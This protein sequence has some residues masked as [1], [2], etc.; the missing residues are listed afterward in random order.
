MHVERGVIVDRGADTH[1][2]VI[3]VPV[4]IVV[5]DGRVVVDGAVKIAATAIIIHVCVLVTGG[6]KTSVTDIAAR[7]DETRHVLTLLQYWC[8]VHSVSIGFVWVLHGVLAKF[9]CCDFFVLQ[10]ETVTLFVCF[11][12]RSNRFELPAGKQLGRH[13]RG[14]TS[15]GYVCGCVYE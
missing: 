2:G 12:K 6:V 8:Q 14:H 13:S 3:V 1:V 10:L 11:A 9:V 15:L 4:A 7:L 5:G